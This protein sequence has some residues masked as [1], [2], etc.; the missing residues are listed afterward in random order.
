MV[1]PTIYRRLAPLLFLLAWSGALLAANIQVQVDRDPVNLD[2]SFQIL[3][4]ADSEPDDE[5]DFSPLQQD[6]TIHSQ[7]Q[8]S[9]V[10]VINGQYSRQIQW[11]L[12]A[13]AKRSG[14]LTIPPIAFGRDSSP[15]LL[16]HVQ[17][18]RAADDDSAAADGNAEVLVEVDAEPKNPYV[19][20]Q[21]LYN[22]RILFQVGL[23]NARLEEPKL[24][25]AVL[26]RLGEDKKF[27]TQRHGQRY[28]AIERR[29]ALFPQ[30][31][32]QLTVQPPVLEAEL[33]GRHSLFNRFFMQQPDRIVKLRGKT[34]ELDVRSIPKAFKG[35]HWLP[36]QHLELS[37]TLSKDPPQVAAG[38]PLTRTLTLKAQGSTVGN[39]PE[40]AANA[41]AGL[42]AYPDQPA[43]EESPSPA[44]LRAS[45]VEKAALIPGQAGD[46]ALPEIAIP[47][48]NTETDREEIARLPAR[49]L[50]ATAGST[51]TAVV[52]PS[53]NAADT[54]P[55]GT[56]ACDN[57][58]PP[59]PGSATA[60][61]WLWGLA[62]FTSLGWLAT[63]LAWGWR[64]HKRPAPTAPAG[65]TASAQP[66]ERSLR[67]R[68]RE[69]CRANNIQITR[70]ALLAWAQAHWPHNPPRH[71][72]ELAARCSPA[73]AEE[74][75][76]LNRA[77]YGTTGAAWNGAAL[78]Q[79]LE[80]IPGGAPPQ[81]NDGL[82]PLYR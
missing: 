5:P 66:D 73:L 80:Q 48:W 75:A 18:G 64:S 12:N 17:A 45:R 35:Q 47:W 21:V 57:P 40:L 39:L 82:E 81:K 71:L 53:S 27:V 55:S 74:I 23:G 22:V 24:D 58:A 28:Q 43:L 14:D 9:Q 54:A 56:A 70:Q 62:A 26:V 79:A 32:G 59:P 77:A 36:A 69:A 2:E 60:L 29:F 19:Q 51:A 65:T 33:A 8:N 7:S 31:S 3:F 10:S 11:T 1:S 6:F 25:N 78:W 49:T 61:P 34:V 52:P 50:T 16:V 13:M 20:A 67:R 44:G 15:A 41:I 68:L 72:D 76:R 46:Y 4:T 38:E 37:E 42:Q 63:A 30:Q